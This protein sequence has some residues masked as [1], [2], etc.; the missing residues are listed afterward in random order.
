[1]RKSL[2][3]T[4]WLIFLILATGVAG[5][6][7][8]FFTGLTTPPLDESTTGVLTQLRDRPLWF[9]MHIGG[10]GL[11]LAL[12]PW[13]FASPLRN[14]WPLIHR[15]MGRLYVLAIMVGGSGGLVMASRSDAGPIAQVGFGLLAILWLTTTSVA[16]IL[17]WR[18]KIAA[19]RRWMIR[20][21]ALTLAAVTLRI[22]IPFSMMVLNPRF[23]IEFETAYIAIAWACWVPNLLIAE[24]YLRRDRR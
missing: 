24:L 20:S 22:Y 8:A 17:A 13:Q 19:H 16:F 2:N 23:G 21:T 12:A 10:G 18:R 5:Y 9:F 15:F 11:A 14:R 4:G 3:L 7:F 1:M 6:A